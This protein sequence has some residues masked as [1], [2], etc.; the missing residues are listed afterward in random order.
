MVLGEGRERVDP[1]RPPDDVQAAQGSTAPH[2][3][4]EIIPGT[5][6]TVV[7][8]EGRECV[9]PCRP[10]DDVQAAQGSTAPHPGGKI[11]PGSLPTSVADPDPGSGA[12]L[13]LGSRIP[14][15]YF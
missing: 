6:P 10:T 14:N 11:I 4:G 15:P 12:F 7:L 1:C 8:S 9:D 5:V 3:G 2:P 13:T